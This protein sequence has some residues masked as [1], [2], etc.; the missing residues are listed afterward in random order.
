M[1]FLSEALLPV[2][3]SIGLHAILKCIAGYAMTLGRASRPGL[4]KK[5]KRIEGA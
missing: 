5:L 1:T 3:Y 2:Y 4:K